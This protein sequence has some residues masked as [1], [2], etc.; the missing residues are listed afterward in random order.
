MMEL[1][2]IEK[3][4]KEAR[5]LGPLGPGFVAAHRLILNNGLP[6]RGVIGLKFC[7]VGLNPPLAKGGGLDDLQA[8]ARHGADKP[9]FSVSYDFGKAIKYLSM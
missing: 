5:L 4:A 3:L 2:T 6:G 9:N 8:A 7:Q 1:S